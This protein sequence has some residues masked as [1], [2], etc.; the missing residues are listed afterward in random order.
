MFKNHTTYKPSWEVPGKQFS[1]PGN[2]LGIGNLTYIWN[3]ERMQVTILMDVSESIS[4]DIKPI[5]KGNR[6]ILEAA[7]ISS[8]DKP[9]KTHLLG[10]QSREELEDEFTVIGFSEVSLRYGYHF[11]LISCQAIEPK[12]IKLILGY[13]DLT[14]N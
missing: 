11:S 2:S 6:V 7:L 10:Q 4:K 13:K 8:F 14:A 9:F 12:M 5:L 1:K 3:P